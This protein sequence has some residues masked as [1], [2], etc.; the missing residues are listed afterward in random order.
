MDVVGIDGCKEG[1]FCVALQRMHLWNLDVFPNITAAW[2]ALQA[3]KL[4]LIDIPIGLRETGREGRRCDQQARKLLGAPRASSV[5]TPPVRPALALRTYQEAAR[6]NYALT[7]RKLSLQ[8]WGI[9]PKIREV[10]QLLRTQRS[11]R[12]KIRE[13]HPE[14]LFWALN[15]ANAMTHSKKR[16]PGFEERLQ[17]LSRLFSHSEAIVDEALCRFSRAEVARDDILDALAAAVTGLLSE[18]RLKTLPAV[19]EVDAAGLPMEIAYLQ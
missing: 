2:Q 17:V 12:E 8:S 11:A 16:L 5:F 6:V 19:P 14:I 15:G 1:W 18:G 9:S 4:I 3:A 10:D 13:I 7:G